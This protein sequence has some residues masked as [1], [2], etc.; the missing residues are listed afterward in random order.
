MKMVAFN[1]QNVRAITDELEKHLQE[2][3]RELGVELHFRGS[4]YST[5][6]IK[7]TFELRI[8]GS[9]P[10]EVR[11]YKN[12]ADMHGLP[13]IGTIVKAPNGEHW[14]LAGWKCRAKKNK[15]V[16]KVNGKR[17]VTTL[18]AVKYLPVVGVDVDD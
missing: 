9:E 10:E 3:A 2:A 6:S 11:D 14:E 4:R 16:I 8:L 18:H 1:K 15:V 5:E 7:T 13:P 12:F 17:Y